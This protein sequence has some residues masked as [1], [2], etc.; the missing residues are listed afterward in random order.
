MSPQS[1]KSETQRIALESATNAEYEV[2]VGEAVLV[3]TN[4]LARFAVYEASMSVI[5]QPNPNWIMRPPT[6]RGACM[7]P[8]ERIPANVRYQEVQ[9]LSTAPIPPK[10]PSAPRST[11]SKRDQH[12]RED[13]PER[14]CERLEHI[15]ETECCRVDV[16][17]HS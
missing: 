14:T 3:T 7:A 12:R 5:S 15:K 11:Q 1:S 2:I 9:T 13:R 8:P 6:V 4:K 16:L 10:S 17:L